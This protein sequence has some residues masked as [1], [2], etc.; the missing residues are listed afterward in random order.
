LK[1]EKKYQSTKYSS[2]KSSKVNLPFDNIKNSGEKI[3]KKNLTIL[4]NQKTNDYFNRN[5]E[6]FN[7]DLNFDMT[8]EKYINKGIVINSIENIGDILVKINLFN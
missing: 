4:T 1:E 5:N 7:K 2:L 3:K 6:K 8:K